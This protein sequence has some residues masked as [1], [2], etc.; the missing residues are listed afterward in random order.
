MQSHLSVTDQRTIAGK[1][2]NL[3]PMVDII[4]ARSQDGVSID[5]GVLVRYTIAEEAAP[6][7][8]P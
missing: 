6:A 5:L 8:E 7:G 3:G 2:Q 4:P 1:N